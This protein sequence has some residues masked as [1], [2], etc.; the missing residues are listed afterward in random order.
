VTIPTAIRRLAAWGIALAA[1][2]VWGV[3]EARAQAGVSAGWDV[4][5]MTGVFVGHPGRLNSV[6]NSIDDWYHSGTIAISAARYLTPHLKLEG[7]AMFSGEGRRY[8]QQFVTVPGVPGVGPYPVG[9]EHRVRTHGF[10]AGVA[11]QFFENQWAHPFV[12]GGVAVDFDRTRVE[13][14][15]QSYFRGDPRVPGNEIV[16]TQHRIEDRGTSREARAVIGTGAKVYMT[17]GSYF[18]TDVRVN[19]GGD[20]SGHVSFRLGF[21]V[22]F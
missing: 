5:V 1:S 12:F 16:L 21:G 8:V 9:S 20:S 10:S 18:K 17:R 4:A 13:T 6:D 22:D 15:P 14:W 11:Y 2:I 3:A 7:E 19:A